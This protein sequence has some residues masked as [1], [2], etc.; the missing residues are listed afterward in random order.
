MVIRAA[1]PESRPFRETRRA[2]RAPCP[3][4]RRMA[5]PMPRQMARIHLQWFSDD[6]DEEGK[7]EQPTEHK[8]RKLREEE[9]QLPK[10]QELSGAVTL[11]LPALVLFFLAPRMLRT[12]AEMLRF[13]FTRATELDPTQDAIIVGV[14]LSYIARLTLPVLLV[15]MVAALVSNLVQVG[16]PLPFATKA[17]TPNFTKII[18]RF[19][20]FFKR[21]FSADGI[22][23]FWKSIVKMIII[24]GVAYTFIRLDFDRLVNL[25][26]AGLWLGL[27][28]V[29]TIAS[30]ILLT[31]A[32][33]LLILSIPD[34]LFQRW[35][36]KERNK[37]SREEI[38]KEMK[39]YDGD[40]QVKHRIRSRF[41][42]LLR[43]N[44]SA[45][46]PNADVVITN[47]THYAV[48]LEYRSGMESPMVSAK[49]TDDLAARIRQIAKENGVPMV[50]NKPLARALYREIDVGGMIPASYYNVIVTIFRN[51]D[52]INRRRRRE[53]AA[54]EAARAAVAEALGLDDEAGGPVP[55]ME[56]A[57]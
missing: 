10:S 18:P 45:T 52:H 5:C 39:M 8:L 9:G 4:P 25:Q 12:F 35:R 24:G 19:G 15:A 27:T 30:R 17:I 7:T 29:A 34:F 22:W 49:G 31:C 51:V 37:M 36:F 55:G 20:Q 33:L 2:A 46:V 38:K 47:P 42:N 54:A 28:T 3:V 23:N 14:A 48:A 13:F 41:Q 1:G 32:L 53:K 43:Q 50:E 6:A 26:R 56:G 11:F 16:L 57:V 44:L 40:P 21:I